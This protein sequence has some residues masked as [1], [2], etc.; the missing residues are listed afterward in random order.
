MRLFKFLLSAFLLSGLARAQSVT[1]S[2][3][4]E[5]ASLH[6]GNYVQFT[7][8]VTGTTRTGVTWLVNGTAGGRAQVGT[9][10][11]TGRY[12]TPAAL[13]GDNAVTV[14]ATSV[15]DPSASGSAT[16]TLLNPYPVV[17]SV[18]PAMIP[19]GAFTVTV[20]GSGFVQGSLVFFDGV[21]LSAAYVSPTRLTASGSATAA[22]AHGGNIEVVVINPDPGST[23]SNPGYARVGEAE[24]GPFAVSAAAAARFLDQAAFG[25]DAATVL[26][27]R[28]VG[29]ERYLDE[30]FTAPVSHYPD[31]AAVGYDNGPVQA[32][33]FSNAVHGVDQLRQRVAFAL[34]QIFV[35]SGLRASQPPQLVPYLE[36]LHR[37]TFGDYFTLMRDITLNPAMGDYLNMVN[38][39]K[40]NPARD[41][42]ANENYARELMQLFTIGTFLLNPDG[43]LQTDSRGQPIPTYSQTNIAEL[44]RALTGWTYPTRPGARAASHNPAYYDEPMVAW[45]PNHDTG[46]KTLLNGLVLPAGQTAEQDLQAALGNIFEHQNLAPFVSKNLIQHLVTGDPSPAYLQRVARVFNNDGAGAKGNLRAVVRAILLDEEARRDDEAEVPSG[47]GH[48]REP[49]LFVVSLLRAL[50]ASVNDTN[51]LASLAAQLGQNVFY[52]PSVFNYYSP[53]YRLPGSSLPAPEFQL[54]TPSTAIARANLVNTLVYSRLNAGT[55]LDFAPFAD[56]APSPDALLE[57]LSTAMFR[58]RMPAEMRRQITQAVLSTTGNAAKAQAAIYLAATSGYY[59]AQH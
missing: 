20:N 39:D 34:S 18:S 19:P 22:Q 6:I 24:S 21:L 30:Q 4:P 37:D 36:T 11:T 27:V 29:F 33:F 9:I 3:Q 59:S 7:A 8:R 31:P 5:T 38:N 2:L 26:H 16:I 47:V 10:T 42:R 25:P 15:E 57:A 43:T 40:A 13:P 1:V 46:S 44:A 58:G 49:V 23:V 56:L 51:T 55:V 41:T 54:H 14:T 28:K 52:S 17:A 53:D 48:L 50:N 45:Q 32:R 35:V 12:T